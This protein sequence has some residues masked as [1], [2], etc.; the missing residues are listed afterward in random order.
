MK[1]KY[2]LIH[3]HRFGTTVFHFHTLQPLS[4]VSTWVPPY[5]EEPTEEQQKF[6]DLLGVDYEARDEALDVMEYEEPEFI[7]VD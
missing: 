4:K 3:A 7:D 2:T 6:L 1:T 5:S